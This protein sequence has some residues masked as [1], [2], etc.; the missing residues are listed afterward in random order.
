MH[1]NPRLT[2]RTNHLETTM[3]DMERR[4]ISRLSTQHNHLH[5][6]L[7]TVTTSIQSNHS[8]MMRTMMQSIINCELPAT[9]APVDLLGPEPLTQDPVE[10]QCYPPPDYLITP[11]PALL[12]PVSSILSRQ[13]KLKLPT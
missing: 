6:R 12:T 5:D 10:T 11:D 4:S 1:N 2:K 8:E 3:E 13:E 7:N 9:E